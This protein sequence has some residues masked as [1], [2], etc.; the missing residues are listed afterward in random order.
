MPL[1]LNNCDTKQV[2]RATAR[3]ASATIQA[4]AH[5]SQNGFTQGRQL[6]Q[7]PVALYFSA[8]VHAIRCA[9]R[10]GNASF[11]SMLPHHSVSKP[12]VTLL[13]DFSTAFPSV[14]PTWTFVF[15]EYIKAPGDFCDVVRNR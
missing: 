9:A 3:A 6:L 7:N 10:R 4:C 15:L 11:D 5:E 1:A 14:F 2:C 12:A 13:L 8:R